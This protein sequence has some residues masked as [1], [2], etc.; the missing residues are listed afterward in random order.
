MRPT[1]CRRAGAVPRVR[2]GRCWPESPPEPDAPLRSCRLADGRA[3][4]H[5]AITHIVAQQP[6]VSL[7]DLVHAD[8]LDFGI[9]AALGAE[10][11]HFLGLRDAADGRSA[12]C[13]VPPD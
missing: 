2:P 3:V 12:D 10:I 6:L 9:N 1:L 7:V 5:E 4:D 13:P 8:H 11:E